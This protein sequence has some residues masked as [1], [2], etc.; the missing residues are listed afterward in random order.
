MTT[1]SPALTRETGAAA[2]APT[3]TITDLHAGY[4]GR[5]VLTD[6]NLT[7]R[8]GEFVGLIGANGAGKTTLLRSLLG[9]VHTGKGRIDILGEPPLKARAH[10]G[11]NTS[12]SGTSPSP[13]KTP[14]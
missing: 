13:S 9:L 7:L 6:L 3:V 8:P 10:I 4:P 11:K 1:A 14:S 12:S 5:P 2:S